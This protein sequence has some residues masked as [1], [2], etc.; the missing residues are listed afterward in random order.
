MRQISLVFRYEELDKKDEQ[1]NVLKKAETRLHIPVCVDCCGN[2]DFDK[3]KLMMNKSSQLRSIL[4]SKNPKA[5]FTGFE[6]DPVYAGKRI[7]D[8]D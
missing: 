3:I 4:N 2:P 6:I 7:T 8:E 5:E 1:G